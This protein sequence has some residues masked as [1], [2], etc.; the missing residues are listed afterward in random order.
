MLTSILTARAARR[1]LPF[2]AA[3]LLLFVTAPAQSAARSND[4]PSPVAAYASRR[5]AGFGG[6]SHDVVIERDRDG[7]RRRFDFQ[8]DG[9]RDTAAMAR[10]LRNSSGRVAEVFDQAGHADLTPRPGT[11]GP[12]IAPDIPTG[13][14]NLIFDNGGAFEGNPHAYGRPDYAVDLDAARPSLDLKRG[15]TIIARLRVGH[16]AS[17][18]GGELLAFGRDGPYPMLLLAGDPDPDRPA[19]DA[20]DM[21]VLFGRPIPIAPPLPSTASMFALAMDARGFSAGTADDVH[22]VTTT[23]PDNVTWRGVSLGTRGN[24]AGEGWELEALLLF[25]RRLPVTLI[26]EEMARLHGEPAPRPALT[27]VLDGSS[28]EAGVGCTD[29]RNLTRLYEDGLPDARIYNVAVGGATTAD[30]WSALASTLAPLERATGRKILV[31]GAGANSLA[32]GVP[33]SVVYQQTANYVAGAHA[34]IPGLLVGV[35]TIIPLA[36]GID[37]GLAPRFDAYNALL[38]R[39]GA[40][41]DFVI[42]RASDR[43]MGD[44]RTIRPHLDRRYSTDGAHPT[45][46]GYAR[47]ASIDLRAIR[48]ALAR[49]RSPASGI[50]Q[51]N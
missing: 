49:T 20:I 50:G 1:H 46:R 51:P 19:R 21:S 10:F 41:A 44:P 28:V 38:R 37:S 36:S 39:G 16:E 26:A 6:V 3:C 12:I 5:L 17:I 30:R 29:L 9:R 34:R 18:A 7:A 33:A 13:D 35:T 45:D 47:L 8:P 14:T 4:L 23:L 27:L 24:G 32:R 48:A 42:D 43:I 31:S 2:R 22:T 15:V 11:R 25:D 40:G